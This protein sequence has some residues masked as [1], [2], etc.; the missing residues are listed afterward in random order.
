MKFSK[1]TLAFICAFSLF[2]GLAYSQ[3]NSSGDASV[4]Q[5]TI[6][7]QSLPD[8]T[9]L[10][11]DDPASAGADSAAAR[12]RSASTVWVFFRMVFVLI[13]VVV[14]IYF[15]M[16]FMRRKMGGDATDDDT[17]LRKVAQVTVAPGKTVQIVTL[18]EHAYLIGVTDNSIDLL[19]EISDKELVDAMNLNADRN[20]NAAR[21]RNF[22]D[23][24]SLFLNPKN[25]NATEGERNASKSISEFFNKQ[26]E[27]FRNGK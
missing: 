1:V 11:L 20:Q 14:C 6:S 10:R 2:L 19:G 26:K 9:S 24:L 27:K 3:D 8:E 4:S 25:P 15:V 17:F 23:V 13:V 22:G 16:N 18:L 21:A 5:S 12:P 7:A